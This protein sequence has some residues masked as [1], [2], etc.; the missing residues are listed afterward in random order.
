MILPI[1]NEEIYVG[2]VF[3]CLVDKS[4]LEVCDIKPKGRFFFFVGSFY[5]RKEPLVILKDR[6]SEKTFE[7]N[8]ITVQTLLMRRISK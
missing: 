4:V 7:T 6:K 1:L 5:E 8:L 2:D 3:E